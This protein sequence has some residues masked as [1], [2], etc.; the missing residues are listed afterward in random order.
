M[1]H[2]RDPNDWIQVLLH[3]RAKRAKQ[4]GPIKLGRYGKRL[5]RQNPE[6]DQC[7]DAQ[8]DPELQGAPQILVF[9]SVAERK[10]GNRQNDDRQHRPEDDFDR[11]QSMRISPAKNANSKRRGPRAQQGA[12]EP[13]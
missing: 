3:I 9:D 2:S 12:E 8:P 1:L 6:E 13:I 4:V 11:S 10:Q 5:K 7:P